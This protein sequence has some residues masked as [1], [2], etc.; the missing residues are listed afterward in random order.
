M[1]EGTHRGGI[2]WTEGE[3]GQG[4]KEIEGKASNSKEGYQ[5]T[6][7]SPACAQGTQESAMLTRFSLHGK[8]RKSHETISKSKR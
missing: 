5:I 3:G 6:Y 2:G 8:S 7:L 4:G 1:K